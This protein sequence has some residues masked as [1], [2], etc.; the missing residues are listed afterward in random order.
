MTNNDI[1]RRLRYSF[2]LSDSQMIGVFALAMREVT[3]AQVSDWLKQDSDEA[4]VPLLDDELVCFLNGLIVEKRGSRE[5]AQPEVEEALNNNV[6]LRKLKIALNL[7]AEEVLAIL[8]L[9]ECSISKHELSAF[10]RKPVHRQYRECKEQILRNFLQ[11]LQLKL[12]G[13]TSEPVATDSIS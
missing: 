4:F 11:G 3:R 2:D 12:R 6:I 5:G 7:Q 9:A 1:L 8:A 10:F 13:E